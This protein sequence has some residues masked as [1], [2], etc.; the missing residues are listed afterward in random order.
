MVTNEGE[1][2][3]VGKWTRLETLVNG[4]NKARLEGGTTRFVLRC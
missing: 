2:M 1:L 3:V 4:G